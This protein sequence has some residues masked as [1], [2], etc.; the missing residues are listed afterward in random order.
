MADSHPC[1]LNPERRLSMHEAVHCLRFERGRRYLKQ[2][3][4]ELANED[5][6][7]G[8]GEGLG[9]GLADHEGGRR[10]RSRL[11]ARADIDTCTRWHSALR[12]NTTM[13][14]SGSLSGSQV[15]PAWQFLRGL[16]E[17][18]SNRTCA[19]ESH[20][21]R[22]QSRPHAPKRSQQLLRRRGLPTMNEATTRY[23]QRGRK[24]LAQASEELA[25]DDL[26]QASVKAWGA[27]SQL[28]KAAAAERGWKHGQ[29]RD[30]YRVAARLANGAYDNDIRNS[31]SIASDLG[32]QLRRAVHAPRRRRLP[33]WTSG[34]PRQQGRNHHPERRHLTVLHHPLHRR[35]QLCLRH[36]A[37]KRIPDYAFAIHD[38]DPRLRRQI[39]RRW[40]ACRLRLGGR[41]RADSRTLPRE[42]PSPLTRTPARPP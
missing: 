25:K 15:R 18:S 23:V 21:T 24:F 12:M 32:R 38:K 42:S 4:E 30:L 14:K 5:L 33:H 3:S 28:M 11:A 10:R 29:H 8:F 41:A 7:A 34:G 13:R 39:A 20:G 40:K 35:P 9:R 16:H 27:A 37:L 26:D 31:F 1:T 2:A 22:R 6:R 17:P 19:W 36:C